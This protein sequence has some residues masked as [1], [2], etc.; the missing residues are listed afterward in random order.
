M[1]ETAAVLPR[2]GTAMGRPQAGKSASRD[3]QDSPV[4]TAHWQL[5][6]SPS[7]CRARAADRDSPNFAPARRPTAVQ[8]CGRDGPGSRAQSVTRAL[9]PPAPAGHGSGRWASNRSRCSQRGRRAT[10][11]TVQGRRFGLSSAGCARID[12]SSELRPPPLPPALQD[13]QPALQVTSPPARGPARALRPRRRF[14]CSG[15]CARIL[16]PQ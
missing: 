13:M 10:H 9:K 8:L 3:L 12:R 4:N 2:R 15:R 11:R 14:C 16:S 5:P 1:T 6:R 7:R